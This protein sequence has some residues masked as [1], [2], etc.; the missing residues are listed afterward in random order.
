MLPDKE[1]EQ[2]GLDQGWRTY[3]YGKISLAHSIHCCLNFFLFTWPASLYC[4]EYV[5]IYICIY[6]YIYIHTHTH[7]YACAEIVHELPLLPN[8]TAS[9]T[10]L[11]K[12]GV[13]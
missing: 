5:Y 9:E 12:L 2:Q 3:G 10:F 11:H 1:P 8:N 4:E 7:T 13:V 6:I